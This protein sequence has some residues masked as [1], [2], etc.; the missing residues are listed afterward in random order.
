MEQILHLI[1]T[2]PVYH[3]VAVTQ[4]PLSRL[5]NLVRGPVLSL[6]RSKV[7]PTLVIGLSRQLIVLIHFS[8]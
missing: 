1:V 7:A 2:Y 4:H 5:Q 8:S 3:T 6:P